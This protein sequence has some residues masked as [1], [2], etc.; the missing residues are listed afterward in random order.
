MLFGIRQYVHILHASGVTFVLPHVTCPIYLEK[1]L[2]FCLVLS[3]GA[4]LFHLLYWYICTYLWLGILHYSSIYL[5]HVTVSFVHMGS[6]YTN[7]LFSLGTDRPDLKV[8]LFHVVPYVAHQWN[9]FGI[10]LLPSDQT[11]QLKI[12]AANHPQ[13]VKE[14]C[15]DMLNVWLKTQPNAT[16]DQ[17]TNA[18]ECCDLIAIAEEIENKLSKSGK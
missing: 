5:Q 13:D 3:Q 6:L 10:Q 18:L 16:W 15:K 2:E 17:L 12:I 14:C 1:L 7:D 4:I 8:L 11:H 9:D